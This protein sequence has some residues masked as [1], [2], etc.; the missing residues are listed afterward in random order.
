MSPQIRKLQVSAARVFA[1]GRWLYPNLWLPLSLENQLL[2][3]PVKSC[4][5]ACPGFSDQKFFVSSIVTSW[6]GKARPGTSHADNHSIDIAPIWSVSSIAHPDGTN[7]MLCDNIRL[8]TY[9][10]KFIQGRPYSVVLEDDHFHFDNRWKGKAISYPSDHSAYP[11]S[12][13]GNDVRYKRAYVS[14]SDGSLV[15]FSLSV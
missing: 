14:Q 4:V 11:Q 8:I 10:Y 15:P 12:G 7:P 6:T 3:H 2:S 1:N 9:L 13:T 5:E